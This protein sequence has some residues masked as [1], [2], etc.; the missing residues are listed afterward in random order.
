MIHRGKGF[1]PKMALLVDNREEV[2]RNSKKYM[3]EFEFKNIEKFKL[4]DNVFIRNET[5]KTKMDKEFNKVGFIVE[6][7]RNNTYKIMCKEGKEF[8]RHSS[9][10]KLWPGN[11]V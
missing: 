4:N 11:V 2:L 10:L 3:N 7:I 9:Q 5:K 1:T 6:K 8:A